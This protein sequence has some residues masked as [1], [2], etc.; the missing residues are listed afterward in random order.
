MESDYHSLSALSVI[1]IK[2][3]LNKKQ[4]DN[5]GIYDKETLINLASGKQSSID[6]KAQIPSSYLQLFELENK[7][8]KEAEDRIKGYL[9]QLKKRKTIDERPVV[10]QNKD[11][12]LL[13]TV[14]E[15]MPARYKK[16]EVLKFLSRAGE[17]KDFQMLE[18]N[19]T[20]IN[21]RLQTR[22]ILVQYGSKKDAK[23]CKN[24]FHGLEVTKGI[25]LVVMRETTMPKQ[26]LL[27]NEMKELATAGL[28]IVTLLNMFT[29]ENVADREY[30]QDM[31]E[32][33]EEQCSQ[34]G[35]ITGLAINEQDRTVLIRYSSEAE[36]VKCKS[37]LD[38]KLFDGRRITAQLSKD[39]YAQ[40]VQQTKGDDELLSG[41]LASIA[42]E[43]AKLKVE[44]MK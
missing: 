30:M 27:E 42:E 39:E 37:I 33:V 36:A 8:K 44:S 40:P 20:T 9:Q 3:A 26:M 2:E 31:R 38:G 1:E 21:P 16:E 24:L 7:R 17:V 34:Y 41:F 23:K 29:A 18:I 4:I 12:R 22:T 14:V 19:D 13:A 5:V 35:K 6:L 11:E 32:D 15:N 28:T 43:E 25:H 10:R